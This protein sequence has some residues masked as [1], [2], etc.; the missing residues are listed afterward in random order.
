MQ[1]SAIKRAFSQL[2]SGSLHGSP[3][4]RLKPAQEA[5]LWRASIVEVQAL[6][7]RRHFAS[8]S[9]SG[10]VLTVSGTSSAETYYVF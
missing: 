7:E 8:F 10:T 1:S 5:R 3:S 9:V 4:R 6:E 2:L